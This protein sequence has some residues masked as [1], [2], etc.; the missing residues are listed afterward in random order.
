MLSNIIYTE[1]YDINSKFDDE[2]FP[3]ACKNIKKEFRNNIIIAI[4]HYDEVFNNFVKWKN[5]IKNN[6]EP[7][8]PEIEISKIRDD[9]VDY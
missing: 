9:T 3:N 6:I 2:K 1:E 5:E 4:Q 7:V 8:Y